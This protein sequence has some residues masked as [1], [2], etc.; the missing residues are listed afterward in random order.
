MLRSRS[1]LNA[2]LSNV[3]SRPGGRISSTAVALWL[4]PHARRRLSKRGDQL[5]MRSTGCSRLFA[6][7]LSG[8]AARGLHIRDAVAEAFPR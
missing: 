1:R 7:G 4:L 2:M 8:S 5:G 6:R 3:R